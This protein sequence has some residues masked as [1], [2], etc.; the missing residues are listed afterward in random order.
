MRGSKHGSEAGDR[1]GSSVGMICPGVM[2]SVV[3]TKVP[4]LSLQEN[5]G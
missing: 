5:S 1:S 4:T 2:T 3:L